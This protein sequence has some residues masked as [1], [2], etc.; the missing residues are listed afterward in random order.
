MGLGVGEAARA[1]RQALVSLRPDDYARLAPRRGREVSGLDAGTVAHVFGSYEELKR[2]QGRMD[3]EDV[4]LIGAAL[5]SEDERVAAEVRRPSGMQA[6]TEGDESLRILGD[7]FKGGARV[8]IG[9]LGPMAA[10]FV[11]PSELVVTAPKHAAGIV[12]V[13][14]SQDNESTALS[15]GLQ[16]VDK[17]IAATFSR[18]ARSVRLEQHAQLERFFDVVL[19]PFGSMD[20][21]T[22][23][24]GGQAIVHQTL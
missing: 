3:M 14:V 7:R 20:A 4:L 15:G 21:L 19:A 2:D 5:L 13:V 24:V 23:A 12:D 22:H 1:L 9:T 16:F 6:L 8:K 18:E 10:L 17:R 11:S